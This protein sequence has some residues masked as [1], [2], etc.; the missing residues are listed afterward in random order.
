LPGLYIRGV[1]DNT[2]K[3]AE[4]EAILYSGVLQGTVDGVTVR[5]H[6]ATQLKSIIDGLKR[7]DTTGTVTTKR[8][9]TRIHLNN[10]GQF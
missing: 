5:Y 3:I 6:S 10:G 1:A 2:S 9:L 8:R 4:L 7:D